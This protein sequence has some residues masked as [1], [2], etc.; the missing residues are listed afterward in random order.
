MKNKTYGLYESIMQE[1]SK[2]IKSIIDNN[3]NESDRTAGKKRSPKLAEIIFDKLG[4]NDN[5]VKRTDK[6]MVIDE[7]NKNLDDSE[8]FFNTTY[9]INRLGNV[10]YAYERLEKT[11]SVVWE[12]K[13]M[14]KC[15]DT[16]SMYKYG[17]KY[18]NDWTIGLLH[19]PE[20]VI[21]YKKDKYYIKV[22]V[23]SAFRFIGLCYNIGLK[24]EID[25]TDDDRVALLY[26]LKRTPA[27]IQLMNNIYDSY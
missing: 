25:Y 1:I 27:E 8:D 15:F 11:Y 7:I 2:N 26:E 12:S 23:L 9:D 24:K 6:K 17:S 20:P 16:T 21:T 18:Y 13:Y 10:K 22:Q 19:Q 4:G 14:N 3:L 5:I